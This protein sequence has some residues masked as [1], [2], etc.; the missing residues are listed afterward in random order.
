[1]RSQ[2]TSSD[3]TPERSGTGGDEKTAEERGVARIVAKPKPN[4]RA[5]DGFAGLK[6]EAAWQG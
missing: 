1:M 6:K 2:A 4:G 3:K 5:H